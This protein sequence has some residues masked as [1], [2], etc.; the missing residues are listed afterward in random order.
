[1][2]GTLSKYEKA[3]DNI[4]RSLNKGRNVFI[5]FLY[6]HPATA[7]KFTREREMAEGRN[8][9]KES[10]I[11]QFFGAKDTVSRLRKEFGSE[12]SIFFVKKDFEKNTVENVVEI[13]SDGVLI[14]GYIKESY[15]RSEL[16]KIL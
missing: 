15:N 10:F 12:L 3:V 6:Q 13:V 2:D 11:D 4:K 14:D 1:M 5:F 7:W 9:P 16:E 8:I